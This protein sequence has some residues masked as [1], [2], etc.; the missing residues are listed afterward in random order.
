MNSV[1]HLLGAQAL[2]RHGA[3]EAFRCG[4][5]S[6]SFADLALQVERAAGALTA[7]G[8]R[9]GERV[10][11]L[12]R[13]TPEYAAAWLGALRAGAVAIGL[14]TK[15][16]EAEYRYILADSAARLALIEDVFVGAR[17]DLAAELARDR[18][19]LIAGDGAP[20]W[21]EALARAPETAA[22][23]AR[24]DDPAFWLYSSGTTGKPKGIIHS[25]RDVLPAG[26]VM[27][28]VIG[29]GPGDTVMTTSKLF[30]AYAL[31]MGFLGSLAIGATSILNP[32]WADAAQV[33]AMVGR[34]PP[35]AFFSV[36]SFYRR[37]LALPPEELEGFRQVRDFVTA[38]ERMPAPV[39]E[40][41]RR[42]TGRDILGV[43]GMSETF[44][45]CLATPRGQSSAS[46]TGEP[47]SGVGT[48]LLT[49]QGREAATGEPGVLWVQ[50]PAL[51]LGYA[52]L[53]E[54]TA[55]QFR[56]GWFCTNDLFVR[57]AE[58]CFTHQGRSDE[59]VK[60]A[61]QYVQ[62][63]E[64]EEVVAGEPAIGDAA[65][66]PVLDAD[67]FERLALFV[68]A[69][70]DEQAAL[71]AAQRNCEDRLPRHKRPKWIRVVAELPRTG[72]G[73]IQRYR[74]REMLERE[75]QIK[76]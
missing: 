32:E 38:G 69:R 10:L 51:A 22:H 42:A 9:P 64:L 40:Q 72:T 4:D 29:L 63:G 21:S 49:A 66:A 73:K 43:Y 27:Q 19:L 11:L 23:A 45:V 5:R 14:N 3:R 36:P 75:L 52:N 33:A 6:V 76:R 55:L 61:G 68:T 44:C 67:G 59:L 65:C 62:P 56:D 31:E 57:D 15:L 74:L 2:A 30:F 17:P 35:T 8:V 60:I 26:Q 41:W 50:H 37:L 20:A 7:F 1:E 25:H 70:G 12:M 48:S 58:G 24:A 53:P 54:K 47:L 34:R 39:L 16:S 28:E 13:D 71:Q 46:R 18:K